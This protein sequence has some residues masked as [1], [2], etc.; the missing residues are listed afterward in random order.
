LKGWNLNEGSIPFTY[1]DDLSVIALV[2]KALSSSVHRTTSYKYG[3]F[4]SLL[5]NLF[6]I[7]E[8]DFSLSFR[9]IFATFSE[10]YYNLIVRWDL[11]QTYLNSSNISAVKTAINKFLLK[12]PELNSQ[13]IPFDSLKSS[14]QIELIND[15]EKKAKINVVGAFYGDTEGQ[16]YNF[17]KS[18]KKIWINPDIYNILLR[19]KNTFEKMNYFEWMKFLEKCNEPN[20]LYS[21]ATKIDSSTKR[22]NLELYRNF[23]LSNGQHKCAY[24][25]KEISRLENKAPVDHI[26]PWS[27]VKDD[28]LWNLT[29]TCQTCNSKK[30]NK[31]PIKDY[32]R[33]TEQRNEIIMEKF[34]NF[35]LVEEDF[36][37][38]TTSK[39][40]RMYDSAIFNGLDK[41]WHSSKYINNIKSED[42]IKLF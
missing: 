30:S 21:L 4:K 2:N 11:S 5:D 18:A 33:K 17:S 41:D 20:K 28:K 22:N 10:T 39:Y 24:C 14:L 15:I 6:N 35:E 25:G 13:F 34:K 3:L 26:I 16:L 1:L 32:I 36:K 9:T 7:D 40:D 31:L 8:K 42:W 38:Y 19:L 29:L 37:N 27:F 23:L 12:Y